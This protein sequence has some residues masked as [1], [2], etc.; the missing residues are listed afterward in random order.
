MT[1]LEKTDLNSCR[2][3]HSVEVKG[4]AFLAGFIVPV[5][6]ESSY[7]CASEKVNRA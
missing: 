4:T 5:P 6:F 2:G 3:S 1:G 7:S